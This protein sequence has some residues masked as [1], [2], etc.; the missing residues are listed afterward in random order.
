MNNPGFDPTLSSLRSSEADSIRN[1]LRSNVEYANFNGASL[2][3]PEDFQAFALAP[4][5]SRMHIY[6]GKFNA[7]HFE[8]FQRMTSLKMLSFQDCSIA[9]V[10]LDALK[11]ARPD[12]L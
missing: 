3:K 11:S 10:A 7:E 6:L 9:K 1:R 12:L 5:L 4:Q 8:V 2:M